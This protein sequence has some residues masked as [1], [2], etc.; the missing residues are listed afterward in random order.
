MRTVGRTSTNWDCEFVR[1]C[2]TQTRTQFVLM[3]FKIC[4]EFNHFHFSSL[5]T[6]PLGRTKLV[7]MYGSGLGLSDEQ[8]AEHLV[9]QLAKT[10][11][12]GFLANKQHI[13][14]E[15]GQFMLMRWDF[16]V[17]K[18]GS[19]RLLEIN[20]TPSLR[21]QVAE[22]PKDIDLQK[23]NFSIKARTHQ[24]Y[25]KVVDMVIKIH[26]DPSWRPPQAGKDHS[27]METMLGRTNFEIA[28]D[29]RVDK[30]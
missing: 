1:G 21:G 24:K 14:R 25:S 20:N 4:N 7:Q 19:F 12:L 8:A 9:K 5:M 3:M 16:T 2:M 10:V 6:V 18:D 30:C 28:Y 15:C 13:E 17:A 26:K 11:R 27:Y 23:G 22:D 29:E